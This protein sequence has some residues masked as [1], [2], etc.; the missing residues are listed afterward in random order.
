M[1]EYIY[2]QM[3]KYI[4]TNN[5]PAI[6]RA[7]IRANLAFGYIYDEDNPLLSHVD[8]ALQPVLEEALDNVDQGFSLAEVAEWLQDKLGIPVTR[9][10]VGSMWNRVRRVDKDN[11]RAIALKRR[12]RK[13]APKTPKDKAEREAKR[14][15]QGAKHS[16]TM[17]ER[18]LKTFEPKPQ[19]LFAPTGDF[20]MTMPTTETFEE[21]SIVFRA[22]DGPQT[23]FLA[24]TEQEVLYGGAAGGGKSYA[25]L[26]DPMRYFGHP[27]FNGLLVRRTND[28]LR[29]LKWK[30]KG[31]YPKAFPGAT[32]REKDSM[33]LFP[34]GAQ[35]WMTYLE[36]DD[37]LSRYQGQAFSW[38][39]FDELTHWNT[40]NA[41]IYMSS[42][43]RN[44]TN[45][46]TPQGKI[47]LS[48]RATTNPGGPGHG[49]VKRMFIDPAP[50]GDPFPA[51][52]VETGKPLV[53]PEGDKL[54]RSGPLFY[55][56]FIPA[57]LSDNP[58][59]YTDGQYEANLMGQNEAK[60]RQLLDGDWSL[61]DGAAF[62]E[63]RHNLHVAVPFEVPNDWR[64]FRS[65]DYGYSTWAAVHWYAIDPAY[66]T[67]VVYR[68]LYVTH[69]TGQELSIMVQEA[70]RGENIQYGMLDSSVWHQ[71]GQTGPSIAEEMIMSGTRWRPADRS[72]GSR[73]NGKN[74]LHELLKID[75]FTGKPGIIFF[76]TCRQIIADLPIIP[77]D[78]DGNEDIDP[79]YTSDHAYDSIRYG[80]MSRPRAVS[81][82]DFNPN[83]GYSYRPASKR[84][85]Y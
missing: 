27:D 47:P 74:R 67:L 77:V 73:T 65:C 60:R 83:V 75:E 10:S 85:G 66:D 36:S 68:E 31:L 34:S 40:P 29:E 5:W 63:F 2:A 4:P 24:A 57:K 71:R 17:R 16:V 52:D 51:T 55:R 50:Y 59:L 6:K 45:D 37:D 54:G 15:L 64:R 56:R 78:P 38:I 79:H 76:N 26:A 23:D 81:A 13:L 84:F 9:M 49:W 1:Q 22:N 3:A 44:T 82:F 39:G 46:K 12:A 43:L 72:S 69:K 18:K 62:P 30:S 42:R 41:W 8:P 58:Y 53:W 25:L 11:P 20:Y 19:E 35:F 32:W 28:E 80:I 70:E 61:A 33:W 7:T 14:K 21:Q 48:M